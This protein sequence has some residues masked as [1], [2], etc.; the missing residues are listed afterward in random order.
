[1]ND[2]KKERPI[3]FS[4]PMVQAILAGEK[5]MT[6][7]VI[8]PQPGEGTTRRPRYKVDDILWVRETWRINGYDDLFG[9][10]ITVEF[11]EGGFKYNIKLKKELWNRYLGQE[12]PFGNNMNKWRPS[13]FMPRVVARILL[14]VQGVR[15]ERLQKISREDVKKEG[16]D[17]LIDFIQLWNSLN[18]K[19]GYSWERN[20]YVYVYEFMKVTQG[21]AK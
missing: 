1:M 8:K 7:L 4:T 2:D 10:K 21:G 5:T 14:K 9:Y 12:M 3:L 19:R 6:R 18:A 15:S 16:L 13:I 17:R 20:P 11:K